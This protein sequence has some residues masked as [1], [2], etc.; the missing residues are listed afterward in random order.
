M[1]ITAT[2]YAMDFITPLHPVQSI[3]IKGITSGLQVREY[4]DVCYQ[5][6]DDAGDI[7]KLIL[8]NYFYLPQCTTQ[9]LCP[10][11]IGMTSGLPGDGLNSIS[12]N[13]ILT[14]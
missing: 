9:L 3:K 8:H 7:Q 14:F 1:S 6:P 13:L 10:R 11:G 4:G 12:E 2:P 5:F